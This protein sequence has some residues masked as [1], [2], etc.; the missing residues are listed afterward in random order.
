MQTKRIAEWLKAFEEGTTI[1]IRF[2]NSIVESVDW[3][4]ECETIAEDIVEIAQRDSNEAGTGRTRIYELIAILPTQERIECPLKVRSTP[5]SASLDN[6]A[7]KLVAT[8]LTL[9]ERLDKSNERMHERQVRY[10][11]REEERAIAL[12]K[13]RSQVQERELEKEAHVKSLEFKQQAIDT[14]L[15]LGMAIAN[16]L[17][18]G[19]VPMLG[20]GSTTE[21]TLITLI[22][23]LS[24][25]QQVKLRHILGDR[26]DE[27]MPFVEGAMI[28]RVNVDDFTLFMRSLQPEQVGMIIS[29]LNMGQAAAA[30][31]VIGNALQ[32]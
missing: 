17:T 30:Q 3:Y 15:P 2:R 12:E 18:N 23:S 6:S 5:K 11:E 9:I 1:D 7:E 25:D 13:L 29:I 22:K 31:E 16:K 8:A 4:V 20:A 26:Y 10:E 19:K 27:L 21:L 28:G 32:N 24:D 14:A